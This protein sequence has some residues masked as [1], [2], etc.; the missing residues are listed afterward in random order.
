MPISGTVTILFT[1]LV[2]ST[3]LGAQLGDDA[4]DQVRRAHFGALRSAVA[5]HRGEEVKN[6]GDGLM[7]AFMS[8]VDAAEAAVAMQRAVA[9]LG[10]DG[11]HPPLAIRVGVSVGEA[12]AE[13]GDWFGS[14]VVEAARLCAV[15]DGGQILASAL[16][17]A[18][19]GSRGNLRFVDAGS[20]ELKGLPAPVPTVELRW[21]RPAVAT[22]PLPPK[23][24][25]GEQFQ[26]V[27]RDAELDLVRRAWKEVADGA[28][29][30]V[31][32][33]GEPGV[34]KTRLA[35]EAARRAR[36]DGAVVLFGRCDE[37]LGVPYQPFVEALRH[38]VDHSRPDD[39]AI[40]LGRH[41]G[42][43]ARLVPDVADLVPGLSP[44]LA[45]DPETEQYRLFDA[46][47]GWL[48]ATAVATGLVLV[49]DDLHWGARPTLLLLRHV[50]RDDSAGRVLLVG[51]YRDSELGRTHPLAEVLA[52]LRR[53]PGVERVTLRGLDLPGVEAFLESAAGHDLD[54]SG[55]ALAAA[56]HD[57]TE[58]NP[59]FV[60]EVLRHLSETGVVYQRDGRW[61]SDVDPQEMGIPEGIREVVGRR[62]SAL[63]NEANKVL[64]AASVIGP[65]FDVDLL[66]SVCSL[67]NDVVLSAVEE[68]TESR[69]LEDVPGGRLRGRFSH[70]LVR[71]TLYDELSLVRRVRLHRAVGEAIETLRAARLDEH[72]A[73]L[74]H[75]F[76]RAAADG[77]TTKAVTYCTR[78]G[79]LALAQL[80]HHQAADHFGEALD[81]LGDD[82]AERDRAEL[83][84]KLGEA[85]RRAGDPAYRDTLLEAA[86][87]AQALGDAGLL[88]AAALAN[89][90]GFWS[91]AGTTDEER[92]AML[93]AALA[94]VG[95]DDPGTRARLLALIAQE[96]TWSAA[97]ERRVSLADEALALARRS[98]NPVVLGEV[99]VAW[100]L[101]VWAPSTIGRR[102]E[103]AAELTALAVHLPDSIAKVWALTLPSASAIEHADLES[104]DAVLHGAT[105]LAERLGEPTG[106]WS[107][108]Y[109]RAGRAMVTGG[110]DEAERLATEALEIGMSASQD[111]APMF[112]AAQ[113]F[114]IR[115]EQGRLEELIP[116][117][118]QVVVDYPGLP[119][120][121]SALAISYAE[122]GGLNDAKGVLD[123]LT[124]RDFDFPADVNRLVGLALSAEAAATVGDTG[125]AAAL[126]ALVLP[127]RDHIVGIGLFWIG[128]VSYYLARTAWV[129]GDVE[130][131]DIFFAEAA[132]TNERLGAVSWLARTRMQWARHLLDARRPGDV[133]RAAELLEQASAAATELGMTKVLADAEELRQRV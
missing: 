55:K 50:L 31:L 99:L 18:L 118:E 91:M 72:A 60:S 13:D 71:A 62:L 123:K 11:S 96:T 52:D 127:F 33:A 12:T 130:A 45:A 131:A 111:D 102:R 22:I 120:W 87:R 109:F 100:S 7:V 44:P 69:L 47:A 49:L 104:A 107:I 51:T 80:A 126:H 54:E 53:E 15:A 110:I 97:F 29:R 30:A 86:R 78:A 93:E 84:L 122:S 133:A 46:V 61:V 115:R 88:A 98:G 79:D 65:E 94:T 95:D 121:K 40:R 83:L 9:R 114:A 34:G 3:E 20:R 81:H 23:L 42:E 48:H 117:I 74:A 37:D 90:R 16:V 21:E 103:I 38:Q 25:G 39:L 68:A 73:E 64:S 58:G 26:F 105:E 6:L 4:A 113:L 128:P 66:R 106:R 5:A 36:E 89:H 119:T 77:E 116:A 14:P 10:A 112:F 19:I 129:A 67:E 57:E 43:L 108:G 56:I 17:A 70:A 125:A 35:A 101:A 32:L 82:A 132:A 8:A 27:G 85:Q 2:G 59:F 92:V 63:S 75:Q 24:A 124:A 76:G 1:D 41:A 28:H